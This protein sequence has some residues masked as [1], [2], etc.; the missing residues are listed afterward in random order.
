MALTNKIERGDPLTVTAVNANF[1]ALDGMV[2]G[3]DADQVRRGSVMH[4]HISESMA[5]FAENE[6]IQAVSASWQRI[7]PSTSKVNWNTTT[8]EA[9]LILAILTVNA[10]NAPTDGVLAL[11]FYADTAVSGTPAAIGEQRDWVIKGGNTEVMEMVWVAEA[12]ADTHEIELWGEGTDVT[13][14]VASLQ[15]WAADR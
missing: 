2:T 7:T 5:D 15:V 8:G 12:T 6:T 1:T 14:Q 13:V 11:R 4:R 10:N 3:I 9:F